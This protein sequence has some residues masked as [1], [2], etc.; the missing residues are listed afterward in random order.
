MCIVPTSWAIADHNKKILASGSNELHKT[1][2][3]ALLDSEISQ[4]DDN[5]V[6][7]YAES[8]PLLGLRPYLRRDV[9]ADSS[10]R[11]KRREPVACL[12]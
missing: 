5:N 1:T 12:I 11:N 3:T 2:A 10:R 8:D 4:E 6:S 7:L 9:L